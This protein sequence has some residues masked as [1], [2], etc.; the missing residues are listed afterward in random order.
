VRLAVIA[1]VRHTEIRYDE[2]LAE[3]YERTEAR[4]KM[5]ETVR[6]VLARWEATPDSRV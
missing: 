1:H 6:E 2:L 5:E 3:G 4:E